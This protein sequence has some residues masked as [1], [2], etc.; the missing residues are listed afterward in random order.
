M[1]WAVI[2]V[3]TA[4]IGV[5]I[6][7]VVRRPVEVSDRTIDGLKRRDEQLEREVTALRDQRVASMEKAFD[8]HTRIDEAR[9]NQ[10]QASR[11]S[12]H[13]EL[14]NVKTHFVH[15]TECR[16]AQEG[17]MRQ[18]EGQVEKLAATT[19]TLARVQERVEITADVNRATSERLT[20]IGQDLAR[21]E[22]KLEA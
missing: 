9:F 6:W 17:M 5:T 8:E 20:A 12:I 1:E 18:L 21:L 11:K 22:G 10:A 2:A 19:Q 14:T 7:L 15:K 16:E 4:L 3:G 13:E